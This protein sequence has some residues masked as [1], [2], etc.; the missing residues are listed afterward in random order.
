MQ[1]ETF[2]ELLFEDFSEY[3]LK[4]LLSL[5][6]SERFNSGDFLFREGDDSESIYIIFSGR[7][8]ISSRTDNLDKISFPTVINGTVLGEIAFF[9]GKPR[10]AS[11][12]AIDNIEAIVIDKECFT[13]IE[14]FHPKLAIKLLKEIIRITAERLRWTDQ[15]L[16]ELEK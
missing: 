1:D 2:I 8:E 6:R 11:V 16:K 5:A 12:R 9:D 4:E 7:V 15:M 10:T 14:R 13:E 3:E